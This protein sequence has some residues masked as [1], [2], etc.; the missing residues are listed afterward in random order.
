[1]TF[2]K[3]NQI[4]TLMNSASKNRK[5]FTNKW[6]YKCKKNINKKIIRYK[7]RWCVKNF[8]QLK[9]FDYYE[10]FVSIIK[11]M[12]YKIIFVITVVNNWNI[13]Q[14][15]VKTAF[16]YNY[17]NEKVYVKIF[18]EYIDFKRF[19]II[20]C[21]RKTLYNFKQAF[22]IWFDT[23]KLFFK[24]FDFLFFN[25]DQNV[26]CDEKTIIII[27]VDD[28]L[29]TNS[30]KQFNKN[31]KTIFNK[32]FH[33]IDLDFITYY[34]DMKFDRNKFQRILWFNQRI[35]LKKIFKNYNFFDN[36]SIAIFIKTSTKLKI[37]FIEYIASFDFK[38]IYQSTIEFF[39]YVMLNIR[40][41]IVYFVSVINQYAFNLD[42]I[43]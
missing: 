28:L 25:V 26:F 24:K 33:I 19:R 32:Q 22:K 11:F 6:I 42:E 5:I 31:I 40:F 39:M 20:C 2:Y 18:F 41:D 10:I 35:Y 30:N 17:V 16:F 38:H 27:Y 4:W 34:F 37:A 36:K 1:M 8:E 23:L 43:H 15:N 13:E 29:I 21:F 9:N 12:N 7:T 14:M 3:N